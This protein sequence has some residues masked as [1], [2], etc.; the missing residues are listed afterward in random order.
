MAEFGRKRSCLKRIKGYNT[1]EER[2][3][4]KEEEVGSLPGNDKNNVVVNYW[5][6]K[7]DFVLKLFRL[8]G[9]LK[10]RIKKLPKKI[11]INFLLEDA[12]SSLKISVF[13]LTWHNI[14]TEA[15]CVMIEAMS[16]KK[17]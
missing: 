16:S 3:G 5:V 2:G 12:D 9:Y 6:I 10:S 11:N 1:G 13:Y 15:N 4:R 17:T 14:F 8:N 7:L